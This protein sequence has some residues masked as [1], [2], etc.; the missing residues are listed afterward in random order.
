MRTTLFSFCVLLLLSCTAFPPGVALFANDVHIEHY[1]SGDREIVFIEGK[2]LGTPAYFKDVQ[3]TVD[4]LKKRGYVLLFE[5]IRAMAKTPDDS[6][7]SDRY[8][9]KIRKL[10]GVY[11]TDYT[12]K[13]EN[14]NLGLPRS[15]KDFIPQSYENTGVDPKTD[16]WADYRLDD[17]IKTY[18]MERG[19]ILLTDCDWKTAKN[20]K[21]KC[22]K[23]NIKEAAYLIETLRNKRIVSVFDSLKAKKVAIL[24]G[25][26]HSKGFF[27]LLKE[28]DSTW[29][30]QKRKNY[31]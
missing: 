24:Y 7:Q 2:H 29:V 23:P 3:F 28:K 10:T 5:E 25:A 17:L 6:I 19:E 22:S 11:V 13:E 27:K 26:A 12:D 4:S 15:A 14:K 9:R 1:K 20:K 8:L 21:Y 31:Y 16:I 30:R 18:E